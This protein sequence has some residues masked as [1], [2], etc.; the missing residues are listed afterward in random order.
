MPLLKHGRPAEDIWTRVGEDEALPAGGAAILSLERWQRDQDI[1]LGHD[2]PLGIRL[3]PGQSPDLI[4]DDLARFAL[5]LLE[6]PV[7]KDGRP[8]SHARQL[9]DR[10][11][12]AGELRATGHLL[13]DQYQFLHRCGVDALELSDDIDGETAA[14]HWRQAQAEISAGYQPAAD[15]APWIA[16]LRQR[17]EA[18]QAAE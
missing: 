3:L 5:V 7:F 17:A 4:A 10:Y 12:F 1:L 13:R 15:G 8:F 11:G 9:R 6:F 18:R 14:R 16:R 2:G